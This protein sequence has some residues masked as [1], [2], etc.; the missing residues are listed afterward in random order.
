MPSGYLTGPTRAIVFKVCISRTATLCSPV[1]DAYTLFNSGTAQ[2][3]WT[4]GKPSRFAT[5]FAFL[6]VEDDKLIGVHVGDVK[7]TV[8][9]VETLVV[10]SD[11]GPRQGHVRNFLQ[12]HHL[13]VFRGNGGRRAAK[14]ENQCC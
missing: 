2:T 14:N 6:R 3:P 5:N 4:L 10:E 1:V 13:W 7:T 9:G 11:C 12:R 8:G